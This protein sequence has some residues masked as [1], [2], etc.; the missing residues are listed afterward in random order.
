MKHTILLLLMG[1]L[2]LVT[3]C[4]GGD[5]PEPLPDEPQ[6]ESR[7]VTDVRLVIVDK[8][9]HN[10]TEDKPITVISRETGAPLTFAYETFRDRRCIRFTP[11]WRGVEVTVGDH[12]IYV[13][14]YLQVENSGNRQLYTHQYYFN[15]IFT[16]D[17]VAT[18]VNLEG[19]LLLRN[20]APELKFR[21]TIPRVRTASIPKDNPCAMAVDY[22]FHPDVN[23]MTRTRFIGMDVKPI[24]ADYSQVTLLMGATLLTG[25]DGYNNL[26]IKRPVFKFDSQ[27]FDFYDH[28][29]E[30]AVEYNIESYHSVPMLRFQIYSIDV[31]P[32]LRYNNS[33]LEVAQ[34]VRDDNVIDLLIDLPKP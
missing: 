14:P 26:N 12:K 7:S 30:V 2:P 32:M 4:G 19:M 25:A 20:Y 34:V 29:L 17:S 5:D 18:F 8:D 27:L 3:A 24:D 13:S 6:K 28:H 10:I 23:Q 16:G 11:H 22:A 15:S 1:L 21:L 33:R 31:W 9:D